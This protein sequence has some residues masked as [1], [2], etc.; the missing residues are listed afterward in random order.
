MRE[1]PAV[2]YVFREYPKM[3]YKGHQA[4]VVNNAAMER[5]LGWKPGGSDVKSPVVIS[6]KDA[7]TQMKQEVAKAKHDAEKVAKGRKPV[8]H[9]PDDY[10]TRQVIPEE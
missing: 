5:D 2:K 7:M 4:T 1:K 8:T 3:V 9:D 6:Y 10:L